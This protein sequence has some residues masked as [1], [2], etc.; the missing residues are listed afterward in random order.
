VASA[1]AQFT[2]ALGAEIAAELGGGYRFLKSRAELRAEGADARNVIIPSVSAKYSPYVSVAFYF[3]RNYKLVREM[4]RQHALYE[5]PYHIQQ[6]SV[7]R[8]AMRDVAFDGPFQ[9]SVNIGEPLG[10]LPR[11]MVGAINGLANP[12]FDRFTSLVTARDALAADDPW[13]FGGRG[14]WRQLLHVDLALGELP[15]FR[16]WS[17]ELSEFD[18]EQAEIEIAK[19]LNVSPRSP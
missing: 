8:N 12:F 14:F 17:S 9:W 19:F 16:S 13:C 11:E 5:F 1:A 2:Q 10:A 3:G 6:F 7:N 15:H 4:E 18:R